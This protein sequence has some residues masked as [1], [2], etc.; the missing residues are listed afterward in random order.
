[1]TGSPAATAR[2]LSFGFQTA[3]F[4]VVGSGARPSALALLLFG[5]RPLEPQGKDGILIP[6]DLGWIRSDV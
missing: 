6:P 1:M 5:P 2:P 3:P 4:G